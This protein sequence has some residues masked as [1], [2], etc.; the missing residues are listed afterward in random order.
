MIV[1]KCLPMFDENYILSDSKFPQ[2]LWASEQF[3]GRT[4]IKA[5]TVKLE[6]HQRPNTRNSD[7]EKHEDKDFLT[8]TKVETSHRNNF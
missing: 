7:L 2:H 4:I 3:I 1:T 5:I 8:A 6:L